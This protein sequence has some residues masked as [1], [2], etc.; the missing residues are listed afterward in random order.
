MTHFRK[1]MD[2]ELLGSWDLPDDRDVVVTIAKVIGGELT[3]LGGKKSKK[4]VV[5]F[6]GK[7][8][9]MVF[10]VTNC[11]A[12]AGMYGNHVEKWEGKRIALYVS[13][14]RDPSSG[15]D[16]P[17]IRVRPQVPSQKSAP[18]EEDSGEA[19]REI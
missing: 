7:E 16:V 3:G 5:T 8:K 15:G 9:K 1:F 10:N 17:C 2:Q 19:R 11:K 13:T 6:A 18:A 4:P 12:V 14:T